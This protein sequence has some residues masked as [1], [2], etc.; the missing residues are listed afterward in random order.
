M[1]PDYID[2]RLQH[3]RQ[4]FFGTIIALIITGSIAYYFWGNLINF[5]TLSVYSEAPFTIS[6]YDENKDYECKVS[7]C[8]IVGKIGE[9]NFFVKKEG[10]KTE[11][12]SVDFKLWRTVEKTIDLKLIPRFSQTDKE[13]SEE[14]TEYSFVIDGSNQMQKMVD[15]SDKDQTAIVYFPKRLEN[16]VAFGNKKIALVIDA[17]DSKE[18]YKIDILKKTKQQLKNGDQLKN[19]V[20]GKWSFDNK[21]FVMAFLRQPNLWLM[22]EEGNIEQ[23]NIKTH[24]NLATWNSANRLI[25]LLSNNLNTYEPF[26][27]QIQQIDLYENIPGNILSLISV[28][29]GKDIYGKSEES[30]YKLILE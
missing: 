16:P 27:K 8:E 28:N 10:Y 30:S 11:I 3:R 25:F 18:I 21:Y 23:T 29:N 1:E 9:K 15:V 5:G 19:L 14:K 20:A 17:K 2:V 13:V 24:I 12:T 6:F 22:D 26:T 4:M 7:P